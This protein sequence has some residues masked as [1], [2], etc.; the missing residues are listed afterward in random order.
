M[1]SG[2]R[3]STGR[4][5]KFNFREAISISS[6]KPRATCGSVA[7][8]SN[9]NFDMPGIKAVDQLTFDRIGYDDEDNWNGARCA[10]GSHRGGA[11]H[12]NDDVNLES[13]EF[14]RVGVEPFV[15]LRS[16][17]VHQPDVSAFDV[18]QGTEAVPERCKVDRLLL[19]V[20]GVPH[21]ADAG[22]LVRRLPTRSRRPT[23]SG[24]GDERDEVPPS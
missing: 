20:G 8:T 13:D 3:I 14:R 11:S 15:D 22:H 7:F 5:V 17:I 16:E 24:S 21:D 18:A 12:G 19:L 9:A 2:T 10:L 4:V 6:T 1:S 23:S